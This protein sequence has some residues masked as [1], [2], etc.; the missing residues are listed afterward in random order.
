M[1][2]V[3]QKLAADCVMRHRRRGDHGRVN[4]VGELANV[5]HRARATLGRKPP[6]RIFDRIDNSHKLDIIK[7]A[8]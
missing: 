5:C 7:L 1:D 2:A 4:L 8:R 3:P 6:S